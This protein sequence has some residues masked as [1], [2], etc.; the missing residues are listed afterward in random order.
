MSVADQLKAAEK[1]LVDAGVRPGM[2]LLD[3]YSAINAGKVGRY[4]ASDANNS[5]A[6]GTVRDK[7]MQQMGG[8]RAKAEAL[9]GGRMAAPAASVVPSMASAPTAPRG[10]GDML[11]GQTAPAA[12]A[13]GLDTLASAF[14]VDDG[15]ARKRK[16]DA[17]RARKRALLDG[18]GSAFG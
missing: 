13:P 3:V 10:M 7:V 12:A 11:Q 17:D 4:N 14:M 16:V 9:L 18:V 8:H 5:G 1:Y 15:I 2:G 6:P